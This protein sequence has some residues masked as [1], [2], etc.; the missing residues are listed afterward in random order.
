MVRSRN[1]CLLLVVFLGSLSASGCIA[2]H[3]GDARLIDPYPPEALQAKPAKPKTVAMETRYQLVGMTT[4]DSMRQS[5]VDNIEGWAENIISETGY[6]RYSVDK[7]TADYVLVMNVRDDGEPN[8]GLAMLSGFTLTII[9]AF[10]TDA[11]T[12]TCELRDH[13]GNNIGERRIKQKM[14]TVIQLLMMFGT[15][16]ASPKQV[17]ERMWRQVLQ[18]VTVWMNE[19]IE[20]R[21]RALWDDP[22]NDR[23]T[24]ARA[25]PSEAR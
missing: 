21:R 12:I 18:D 17:S 6:F 8:V 20:Q 16:F 2:F 19:T 22:W 1:R 7:K 5:A 11:F 14:T 13:A 23:P 10:A 24:F 9:P 25:V 3:S 15:P 4:T